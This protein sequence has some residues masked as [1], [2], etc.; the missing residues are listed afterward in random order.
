[1]LRKFSF[2]HLG[3]EPYPNVGWNPMLETN[4][5]F[6]DLNWLGGGRYNFTDANIENIRLAIQLHKANDTEKLIAS[7][8]TAQIAELKKE[9]ARLIHLF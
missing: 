4:F 8:V 7:L 2:R 6:V 3:V 1:M 5:G 9:I